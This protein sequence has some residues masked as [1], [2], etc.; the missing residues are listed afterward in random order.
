[1]SILKRL[2]DLWASRNRASEDDARPPSGDPHEINIDNIGPM[3]GYPQAGV[4]AP[5]G[6]VRDG[7][8]TRAGQMKPRH[9]VRRSTLVAAASGLVIA[10]GCGSTSVH[11]VQRGTMLVSWTRVAGSG[12]PQLSMPFELHLFRTRVGRGEPFPFNN[13]FRV[14][15]RPGQWKLATPWNRGCTGAFDV[16]AGKETRALMT[17]KGSRCFFRPGIA[18]GLSPHSCSIEPAVPT[19]TPPCVGPGVPPRNS[20][21]S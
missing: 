12:V 2:R 7:V 21:A 6:Y 11:H 3:G 10:A 8:A 18:P 14:R 1:M 15:L 5:A 4:D 19:S 17:L 13:P 16:Q 20:Q 9:T